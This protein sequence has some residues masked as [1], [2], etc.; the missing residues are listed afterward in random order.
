LKPNVEEKQQK[1]DMLCWTILFEDDGVKDK[2]PVKEAL[3]YW[4]S[5]DVQPCNSERPFVDGVFISHAH[6]DHIQ[7]VSFLDPSIPIYCTKQTE[8]LAKAMSDVSPR[9]I[10]DQY[11]KLQK[12]AKITQKQSDYKVLCPGEYCLAENTKNKKPVILYPKTKFPFTHEVT[13]KYRTFNTDLKGKINGIKYEL[14][15]VGHSVPGA[16]S[17]LL[18]LPDGKRVLYTG[19]IRFHGAGEVSIDDYVK[20]IGGNVDVMITEG[21][22]VDSD[23]VITEE[24]VGK[25]I[26]Q[27]I[28]ACDGLVLISFGWKDLTRFKTVYE[29]TKANKRTL[30]ILPKLAYLL[31]EMHCNFPKEYLDPRKMDNLKVYL[32]REGELLYSVADYDKCKWKLGYL[33]FHGRNMSRDDRN[34]VRI[35]ERLG[36]GG[37]VNNPKNPLPPNDETC[38]YRE[39]Y[40]LALSHLK[41]G[42]RAYHIRQNPQQYVLMF[43]FWDANEL[44][45]LIPQEGKH[46]T[47]YI[48]ASTEPFSEE[49]EIDETKMF[50]WMDYFNIK[51]ETEKGKVFKRRHVS[52]HASKAEIEKVIRKINPKILIPIHTTNPEK[53]KDIYPEEKIKYPKYGEPIEL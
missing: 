40:D 44:F 23:N 8:I 4:R 19:D 36:K 5:A 13:P 37:D 33:H 53:F 45:D 39:I 17:V 48:A 11:Y 12:E 24:Q 14:V 47:R 25:D 16:C 46:D 50:K 38:N 15:L 41:E 22:R 10:D 28:D 29:A 30:V 35:A 52:G 51:Y 18:T 6:F 49:M 27:D 2:V 7:D 1:N 21:T 32:R 20:T 43:S 34:L 31:Y 9:G 3:D 26:T 42:I